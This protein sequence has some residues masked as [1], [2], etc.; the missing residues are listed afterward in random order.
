MWLKV[1]VAGKGSGDRERARRRVGEHLRFQS[2]NP[3]TVRHHFYRNLW[4]DKCPILISTIVPFNSKPCLLE[5]F[6]I[7]T[8][9]T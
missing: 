7:T 2:R 4:Q 8:A 9:S 1:V 6:S 5:G 3:S